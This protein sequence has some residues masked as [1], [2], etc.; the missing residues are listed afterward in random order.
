FVVYA[1]RGTNKS[2]T[3]NATEERPVSLG[4]Q[5]LYTSNQNGN[6]DSFALMYG[7]IPPQEIEPGQYRGRISFTVEPVGSNQPPAI[8]ILNI[9]AEIETESSVEITTESGAKEVML[10]SDSPENSVSRV[11]VNIKGVPGGQFRI[12]QL[13]DVQ[14]VSGGT[15]SF[16][17]D[18][19]NFIGRNAQKG[20]VINQPTSLSSTP[21]V[22]YTSSPAGDADSFIIEYSLN[23]ALKQNAG[24]YRGR[25]K[26]FME[27]AAAVQAR[28]LDTLGLEIERPRVFELSITPE[29]GGLIRFNDVKLNQPPQ[30]S[31]I[32][33][34]IKTNIGRPYQ[35][36]QHLYSDLTNKEGDV[37]SSKNFTLREEGVDTKGTL[38]FSSPA[39]VKSGDTV[40]FTS[41]SEGSSDNFKVI[42]ELTSTPEVKAGDYSTRLTYSISEI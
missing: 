19:V 6:S 42:Y 22:V 37:I 40:L 3:L 7:I 18:S 35:V 11:V 17:Y 21:Q 30:T 10:K 31:E 8:V 41:D 36:N 29:S 16:D 38:K 32:A 26:Y 20:M 33:V 5:I 13:A 28:P 23:Q 25:I 24:L 34:Q 2:G 27:G 14:P 1:I 15:A 12:M 9:F 4:R 39:E